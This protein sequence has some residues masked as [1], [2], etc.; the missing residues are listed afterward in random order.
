MKLVNLKYLYIL[1]YHN[2]QVA[3]KTSTYIKQLLADLF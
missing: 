2:T 3:H 1:S